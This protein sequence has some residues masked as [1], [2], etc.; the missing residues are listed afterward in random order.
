MFYISAGIGRTGTFIALDFM[1]D[2]GAAE[3]YVDV[4]SY[5]A[6]LR[7]QRGKCIQ[8]YVRLQLFD[9]HCFGIDGHSFFCNHVKFVYVWSDITMDDF[10]I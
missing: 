1:L 9:N 7:Q 2:E 8:T 10:I 4:K 6:S 5:V 3:N